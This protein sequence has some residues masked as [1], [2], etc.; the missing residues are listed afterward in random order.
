MKQPTKCKYCPAL[1]FWAASA[2]SGKM[3]PLE[4]EPIKVWIPVGDPR[5]Q[6]DVEPRVEFKWGYTNH[7]ETCP[8]ADQARAE[9]RL[10][11]EAHR[12]PTDRRRSG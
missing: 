10:R 8:G 12:G 7:F 2:K 6:D 1:L 4:R 9:A 3:P 11:R 5:W